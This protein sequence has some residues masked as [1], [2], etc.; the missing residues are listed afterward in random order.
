MNK[1]TKEDHT[2]DRAGI[3]RLLQKSA[4]LETRQGRGEG[5]HK[6]PDKADEKTKQRGRTRGQNS[7]QEN[8]VKQT[9]QRAC[10]RQTEETKVSNSMRPYI[11]IFEAPF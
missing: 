5:P 10:Q 11:G 4:L 1:R 7:R 8:K 3:T 6:Y 9:R 2:G